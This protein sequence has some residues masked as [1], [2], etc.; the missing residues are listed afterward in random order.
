M[1]VLVSGTVGEVEEELKRPRVVI[2]RF[3]TK[4]FELANR[5]QSNWCHLINGEL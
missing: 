3:I 1:T 5:K 2:N 4:D